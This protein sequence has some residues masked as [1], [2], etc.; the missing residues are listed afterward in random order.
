MASQTGTVPADTNPYVYSLPRYFAIFFNPE[1][2]KAFGDAQVRAA[3]AYAT[4]K[5]EILDTALGGSGNVVDSPI[6][7]DIYG[8]ELP[9][10]LYDYDPQ[11]AA[12]MLDTAGYIQ[13]ADGLRA[14]TTS[15]ELAFQF[16]KTLVKG[17]KS[18]S[19]TKELQKCLV[20]EVMPDLETNGN[21]GDKTVAAVKLFQEKYRADI[22]DPQNIAEPNGD[23]KQA[24]RE[25]LNKVCF[26]SG[27]TTIALKTTLTVADQEP[28]ITA[29]QIIK[30]QWA[31]IGIAVDINAV[32][33]TSLERD[34][35]KP[36][37]YEALL[38]GQA[39]GIIPDPYPFW[40][41][42]QKVDPGLN[43]SL[44]ENK[45]ADKLLEDIRQTTDQNTRKDL[46]KKFEDMV[47]KDEPAIF[48]YN[49]NH[50]FIASKKI[51]GIQ[52]GIIADPGQRFS[53]ISG[54]FTS[55]KRIW[56]NK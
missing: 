17:T 30:S 41:S 5:Q 48:L 56:K 14:K 19:D 23:V 4:D 51:K 32:E 12:Q 11:K 42:S 25:K 7:S 9:A 24:T 16:T 26:P 8:S 36:R 47:T 54:W 43:F 52:T 34:I 40:H 15:R 21:F 29:A 38:F 44:Y 3:L 35:V 39:M 37:S 6:P 50:I 33:R 55:T 10:T 1:N 27:D 20:R 46:L 45:D 31:K 49:P 53:E 28:F 13:G 22:L 2:N 18:T